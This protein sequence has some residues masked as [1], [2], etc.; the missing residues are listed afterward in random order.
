MFFVFVF[1]LSP[2][3]QIII[4]NLNE[5]KKSLEQGIRE[6]EAQIKVME[7]R[8]VEAKERER[9][10]IEYPDLNGPVNPDLQGIDFFRDIV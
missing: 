6:T 7:E 10:I 4:R 5:E 1:S 3:E 2:F 8:L 9:L